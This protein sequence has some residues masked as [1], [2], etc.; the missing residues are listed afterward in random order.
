MQWSIL[1]RLGLACVL[2]G[3][4]MPSK[5]DAQIPSPLTVLRV[6]DT[7]GGKSVLTA[8]LCVG[9]LRDPREHPW[10]KVGPSDHLLSVDKDDERYPIDISVF[11]KDSLAKNKKMRIVTGGKDAAPEDLRIG[12]TVRVDLTDGLI[13]IVGYSPPTRTLKLN[14]AI[15]AKRKSPGG[16]EREISDTEIW[17]DI[18]RTQL[19]WLLPSDVGF[20]KRV[21]VLA[22]E[23]LGDVVVRFTSVNTP[24]GWL[25]RWR[26]H[27]DTVEISAQLSPPYA[28]STWDHVIATGGVQPG[29]SGSI[30]DFQ[31]YK[32]AF[33]GVPL[34]KIL[35]K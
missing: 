20:E 14:I 2:I 27:A 19:S 34:F 30:S 7:I 22:S 15:T 35:A 18:I 12:Q 25:I 13:E 9:P 11:V 23:P 29:P 24:S 6:E 33:L 4:S 10:G 8:G 32:S 3:L 5:L 28:R 1:A 16:E 17:A 31:M 21:P 26:S